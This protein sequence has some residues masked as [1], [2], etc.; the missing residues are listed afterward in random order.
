MIITLI[1]SLK[2]YVNE[3]GD[4]LYLT[5]FISFYTFMVL[6]DVLIMYFF[7]MHIGYICRNNSTIET[8]EKSEKD[9]TF[10][11]VR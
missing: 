1:E 8:V 4:K 9:K 2:F 7:S 11:D 6:L 3:Y 5:V 10:K